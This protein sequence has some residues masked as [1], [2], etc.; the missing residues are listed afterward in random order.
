MFLLANRR[1]QP[2]PGDTACTRPRPE[3]AGRPPAQA[4]G[5]TRHRHLHRGRVRRSGDARSRFSPG[6][7]A[8]AGIHQERF[9]TA[10]PALTWAAWV[11][12]A[13][14]WVPVRMTSRSAVTSASGVTIW[15]LEGRIPEHISAP[16]AAIISWG[17]QQRGPCGSELAP[18]PAPECSPGQRRWRR[19][20][21]V[22]AGQH[23]QA[24]PELNLQEVA[25]T[26][27]SLFVLQ[28]P[29]L[30]TTMLVAFSPTRRLS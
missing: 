8:A 24:V 30:L 21:P 6:H 11:S 27:S 2:S 15:V 28:P 9:T 1:A 23:S 5:Q 12:T 17:A 18:G 22:P 25:L 3:P 7:R 10:P 16:S 19:R 29:T 4:K 20:H 26:G 14:Q 13:P